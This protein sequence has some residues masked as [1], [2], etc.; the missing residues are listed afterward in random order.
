[1]FNNE[2][3]AQAGRSLFMSSVT[4]LANLSAVVAAFIGTPF[5][6]AQTVG[7]VQDLSR[8]GYGSGM[9]GLVG[10]AW[11]CICAGLIF[12]IS[13]ASIG[14]ALVFGGLAIATRFL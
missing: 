7:W 11:F 8:Q 12:F 3:H 5:I 14:T 13:R 9:E 1:M 10:M 2:K 4:G 6:Y